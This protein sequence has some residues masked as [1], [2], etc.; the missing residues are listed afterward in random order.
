MLTLLLV[1]SLILLSLLAAASLQ[2]VFKGRIRDPH[3]PLTIILCARNEENNIEPC[4]SSIL[5]QDYPSSCI[6]LIFIDDASSDNTAVIAETLL[7]ASGLRYSLIRNS[8]Q[9]GKKKSLQANIPLASHELIITRDADTWTESK[10]WLKT[11]ADY[12]TESGQAL[13]IAPIAIADDGSLLAGL[14]STEN[15][16]LRIISMGSTFLGFPF[17]N[18]GANFAFSK[19]A[20]N[21]C[22]GYT[23]HLL[24]ESG[25]DVFFLQDARRHPE[26]KIG[27]LKSP[28]ALVYTQPQTQLKSLLEQRVRWASKIVRRPSAPALLLGLLNLSVNAAFLYA[29]LQV[30]VYSDHT[31]YIFLFIKL[32]ID[33]L[34]LFLGPG[35]FEKRKRTASLVILALLYPFYSLAVGI[36]SLFMKPRWK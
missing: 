7:R 27:F 10:E 11:L 28:K 4:L 18:S 16:I 26:L 32:T 15:Q 34:L 13:V 2:A 20:F 6:E 8:Q 35:I 31:F 30:L 36:S 19:T 14:Q 17:L 1:Y 21:L 22:E 3:L 5:Q 24:I 23:R 33:L 25:E 29:L 9:Q 12:Y